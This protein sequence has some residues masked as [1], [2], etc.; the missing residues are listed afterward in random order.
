MSNFFADLL[1]LTLNTEISYF[2]SGSLRIDSTIEKGPITYYHIDK[3]FSLPD[4][5]VTFNILGKDLLYTL[6]NRYSLKHQKHSKMA[7]I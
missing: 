6:E 3:I 1:K 2:N 4:L 5:V 7:H